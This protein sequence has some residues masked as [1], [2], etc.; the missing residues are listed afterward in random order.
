MSVL[1]PS[2]SESALRK[3]IPKYVRSLSTDS[4]FPDRAIDL[5]DGDFEPFPSMISRTRNCTFTALKPR[6]RK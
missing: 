1:L 6:D 2:L 5:D 4:T 3:P